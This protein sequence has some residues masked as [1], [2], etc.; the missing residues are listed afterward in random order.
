MCTTANNER[1]TVTNKI[2]RK[3]LRNNH[4]R[5][6]EQM[7]NMKLVLALLLVAAS[8]A[9]TPIS[10]RSWLRFTK[11][12]DPTYNTVSIHE[13]PNIVQATHIDIEEWITALATMVRKSVREFQDHMRKYTAEVTKH[14]KRA[15]QA[16]QDYG[17]IRKPELRHQYGM[18][19][20]TM[21][22]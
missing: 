16:T 2:D 6:K 9:Y 17:F 11:V 15:A 5:T 21:D 14:I 22:R 8:Y 1:C 18:L 7:T 3:V 4:S 13:V 12:K 20:I 19:L 10:E